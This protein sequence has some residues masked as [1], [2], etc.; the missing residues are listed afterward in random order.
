MTIYF[1]TY[2]H[3]ETFNFPG[4]DTSAHEA[5]EN[6]CKRIDALPV[7]YQEIQKE[8]YEFVYPDGKIE[9]LEWWQFSY[10]WQKTLCKQRTWPVTIT[11]EK[12][13]GDVTISKKDWVV[14]IP[15]PKDYPEEPEVKPALRLD[16]F[17][18]R[19]EYLREKYGLP[20]NL[21]AEPQYED[22]EKYFQYA[23]ILEQVFEEF[24]KKNYYTIEKRLKLVRLFL[25]REEVWEYHTKR[26][27]ELY[28][29]DSPGESTSRDAGF[30]NK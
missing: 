22:G 25:D 29:D 7:E 24:P 12:H 1:E 26:G 16:D 14:S 4:P 9:M 30:W 13:G 17:Y 10:F 20:E 2:T 21:N 18:K 5:W 28:D 8:G 27:N 15:V 23:Y 6:E 11:T 19:R 3:Q